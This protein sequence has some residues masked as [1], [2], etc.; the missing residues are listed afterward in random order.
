VKQGWGPNRTIIQDTKTARLRGVPPPEFPIRARL[1][2]L[3]NQDI[4]QYSD[5]DLDAIKD[6]GNEFR[7]SLKV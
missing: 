7:E 3:S 5:V 6:R 2:W 1:L 4:N